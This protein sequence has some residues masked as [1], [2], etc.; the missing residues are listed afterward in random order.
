MRPP[1]D[2]L[3]ELVPMTSTMVG[4]VTDI[5]QRAFPGFFLSALGSRFLR[6]YYG[7]LAE[8][9]AAIALVA[10]RGDD[11]VGFVVG[12]TNPRG[13]YRRLLRQ[14]W[15]RFGVAALPA[16][17]HAPS[18]ITRV[19]RAMSHPGANPEG[20]HVGGLF[21]IAV[22]PKL[23][24]G[25]VGHRLIHRFVADARDRGVTAIYLTTDRD[26]N[27]SVNAFYLRNGFVCERTFVTREGR[28]MNE[29]W[30]YLQ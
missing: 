29:Y 28:A 5:H 20:R 19:L 15:L 24:S 25:G 7:A 6:M 12:A 17:V 11:V 26:H 9:P 18:R 8:D 30:T 21:S 4:Q 23:Q 14:R 2:E 3:V 10:R 13:Y 16:V 22:D 27:D 1:G